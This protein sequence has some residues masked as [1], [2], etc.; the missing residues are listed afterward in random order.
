MKCVRGKFLHMFFLLVIM[1]AVVGLSIQASGLDEVDEFSKPQ[2][3]PRAI[4]LEVLEEDIEDRDYSGGTINSHVQIIKV[5][6]LDGDFE[7]ERVVA[8]YSL[9]YGLTDD[10]KFE[11]LSKGDRVLLYIEENDAGNIGSAYVTEIVRE[12]YLLYLTLGFV[13]LLLLIGRTKGVKAIISLIITAL[14]IVRILLP[15]ILAGWDPVIISVLVGVGVICVSLI[16]IGGFTAKTVAA[17]IGT[18]GGVIAAG[19]IALIIGNLAKLTGLGTDETMM[20]MY[21]PQEVEFNFR[22]LLFAGIIIGAMGA[23]MDVG[24][25]VASA[26][27]EIK[28]KCPDIKASEFIKAGMN[29]GRDV[30][31]TM[32]NTLILAYAGASLHLMLLLLA[33]QTPF[34]HV[35]NTDIIASEI[36]RAIAGSIGIVLVVPLTAIAAAVLGMKDNYGTD[37]Q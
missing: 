18:C 31:A 10:Y 24:M 7:G 29:V 30:M 22:G 11:A 4:V 37:E 12:R 36:L 15:A 9:N 17:I 8:Q 21:I 2:V 33:Y 13:I 6:I 35:V 14:A 25:S 1:G 5:L 27:H 3:Y 16:V 28:E 32:T 19:V 34:T 26:M 20:L 23:T